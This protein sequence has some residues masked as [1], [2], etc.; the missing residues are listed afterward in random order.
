L[1]LQIFPTDT[2]KIEPWFINGWQ[3]YGK[4]NEMPG[5]GAQILFRPVEWFS[6]LTN[7]YWGFDA[8]DMPGLNRWHSDNSA[9][10]RLPPS[11]WVRHATRRIVHLRHRRRVRRRCVLRWQ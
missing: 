9:Q 7:D 5:F 2:L 6:I 4:F 8:Q 3:T 11:R 1:R 10:F